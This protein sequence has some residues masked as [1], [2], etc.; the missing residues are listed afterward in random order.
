VILDSRF[1]I[2]RAVEPSTA[3]LLSLALLP[4]ALLACPAGRGDREGRAKLEEE[5]K[6]LLKNY[7]DAEKDWSLDQGNP[8][9]QRRLRQA[10]EALRKHVAAHRE[11]LQAMGAAVEMTDSLLDAT[12]NALE[13]AEALSPG[14]GGE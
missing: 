5:H 14:Q 8:V 11:E 12:L 6:A 1:L 4:L 10:V 9:K 3:L 13:R 7:R 2:L